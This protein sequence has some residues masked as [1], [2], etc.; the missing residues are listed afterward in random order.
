MIRRTLIRDLLNRSRIV[1][2]LELR[3]EG[4]PGRLSPGFSVT[5][6]VYEAHGTHS[7]ESRH[8]R[9]CEPDSLGCLH[10]AVLKAFPKL[11]PLVALHLSSSTGEPMHAEPNGFYYYRTARH[12]SG[13][14]ADYGQAEREGLTIQEFALRVA[15]STLRVDSIPLDHVSEKELPAAFHKFVNEQRE[16]WQR[17]A[18]AGRE[19]LQTIPTIEEQRGYDIDGCRIKQRSYCQIAVSR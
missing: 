2:R 5:A 18:L 4:D 6:S 15:C 7:G 12:L 10:D 16:R 14:W 19:Q 3:E 13:G 8:R 11:A 9:E 1:V 17:E